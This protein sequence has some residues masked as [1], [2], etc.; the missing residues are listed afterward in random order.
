MNIMMYLPMA[1]V[2][3]S[4]VFY[5][6][7]SKEIPE[8]VNPFASLTVTYFV[9][10]ALSLAMYFILGKGG[11]IISE[12]RLVNWTS[13]VLGLSI[14]GLEAGYIYL[15]KSG[16]NISVAQLTQSAILTAALVAVGYFFYNEQITPTKLVGIG[17]CLFGLVLVNM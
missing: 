17:V 11:N 7:C 9:G 10:A 12:L 5:N 16:W 2:V 6:V 15:Y 8:K 3:F 4:N 14:V 1:L 13:F